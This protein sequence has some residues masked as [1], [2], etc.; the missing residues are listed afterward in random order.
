MTRKK[1]VLELL[2]NY[3]LGNNVYQKR[4]N[5]PFLTTIFPVATLRKLNLYLSTGKVSDPY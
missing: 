2:A 3:P 5:E 1:G 4:Q